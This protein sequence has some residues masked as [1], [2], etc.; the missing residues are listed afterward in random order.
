[1][2]DQ[3]LAEVVKYT[4]HHNQKQKNYHYRVMVVAVVGVMVV[5]VT[6]EDSAM[7]KK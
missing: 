3:F 2:G 1:M 7:V 4:D 6:L 5:G